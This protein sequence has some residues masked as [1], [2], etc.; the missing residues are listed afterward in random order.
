MSWVPQLMYV[1][2]CFSYVIK[3]IDLL[4]WPSF[5]LHCWWWI[6]VEVLLLIIIMYLPHQYWRAFF[7][8]WF[9]LSTGMV[10][11]CNM[12]TQDPLPWGFSLFSCLWILNVK[13]YTNMTIVSTRKMSLKWADPGLLCTSEQPVWKQRENTAVMT[14]EKPSDLSA[15]STCNIWLW[16]W[17]RLHHH[18]QWR[19]KVWQCWQLAVVKFSFMVFC[20][21]F[22]DNVCS[23]QIYCTFI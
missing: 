20:S 21:R 12:G 23:Q 7:L 11:H 16:A 8:P 10:V 14:W 22:G 19:V 18:H 5:S 15:R 4:C 13:R 1:C 9:P 3:K 2:C 6:G 17:F